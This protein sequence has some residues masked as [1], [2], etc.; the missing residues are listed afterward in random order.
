M[1]IRTE[2]KF[3]ECTIW[4]EGETVRETKHAATRLNKWFI[5]QIGETSLFIKDTDNA[6]TKHRVKPASSTTHTI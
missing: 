6:P 2:V 5:A 3:K 4:L 1:L